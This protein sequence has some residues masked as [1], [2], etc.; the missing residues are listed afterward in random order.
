MAL[1]NHVNQARKQKQKSPHQ[2]TVLN[3]QVGG[4]RGSNYVEKDK[5]ELIYLDNII[6]W[7]TI[8]H[9]KAGSY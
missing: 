4:K 2:A 7:L 8:P 3:N 6:P 1:W 5:S 9:L